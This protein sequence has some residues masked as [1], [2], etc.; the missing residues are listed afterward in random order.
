MQF[1]RREVEFFT[2]W[3]SRILR[4]TFGKRTWYCIMVERRKRK[5]A[6]VH[7]SE[8]L[9]TLPTANPRLPR[10]GERGS[11]MPV[12]KSLPLLTITSLKKSS[13]SYFAYTCLNKSQPASRTSEDS[14]LTQIYR[15]KIG[16]FSSSINTTKTAS[17]FRHLSTYNDA[18]RRRTRITEHKYYLPNEIC[19]QE[20]IYTHQVFT[21]R[22]R[23][24]I[25]FF[26][27]PYAL[28]DAS[29]VVVRSISYS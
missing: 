4:P 20:P 2:C 5:P 16:N 22:I 19:S 10:G 27:V 15:Q 24:E 3:G 7:S 13:D 9:H 18:V 23:V 25:F 21:F 14:R 11:Q 1:H 29:S 6:G 8:R 28:D 12:W 17:R 26:Y